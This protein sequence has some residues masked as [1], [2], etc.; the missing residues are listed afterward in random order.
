MIRIVPIPTHTSLV[1]IGK[2]PSQT[3]DV[4]LSNI[5]REFFHLRLFAM[6][7]LIVIS[8]LPA[9]TSQLNLVLISFY[10]TVILLCYLFF[11]YL[12]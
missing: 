9:L 6:E 7:F 2:N 4:S 1:I 10:F 11:Y 5:F 12:F 8:D 3:F